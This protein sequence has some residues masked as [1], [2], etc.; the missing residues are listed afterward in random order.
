MIRIRTR[1]VACVFAVL[2]CQAAS[3][4]AEPVALWRGTLSLADDLEEC[5]KG[6][7]PGQIC[8]MHH[9]THGAAG[10]GGTAWTCVCA[11]SDAALASIVGVAGSL[12]SPVLE[13]SAPARAAAVI[14]RS[15]S[16]LE[17]QQPP[18]SPPPRAWL[19]DP[20]QPATMNEE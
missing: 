1:I 2:V 20:F 14:A 5:C 17:R 10:R 18:I 3:L 19:V 12:P 15:S 7:A 13:P 11:P 6:L 8:P 4:A 9:K 16:T